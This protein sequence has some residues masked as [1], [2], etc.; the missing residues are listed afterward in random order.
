MKKSIIF[1]SFVMLASVFSLAQASNPQESVT[2][3]ASEQ[4]SKAEDTKQDI[5]WMHIGKGA[6]ISAVSVVIMCFAFAEFVKTNLGDKYYQD[7]LVP[8]LFAVAV[9][10]AM[11]YFLIVPSR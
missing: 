1:T 9:G 5:N 4:L 3:F 8:A 10:T 2:N 7:K 11:N 6:M